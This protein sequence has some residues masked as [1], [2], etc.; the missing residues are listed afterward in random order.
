MHAAQ[1]QRHGDRVKPDDDIGLQRQENTSAGRAGA[2]PLYLRYTALHRARRAARQSG[3]E[4]VC[5]C[6]VGC[7]SSRQPRSPQRSMVDATAGSRS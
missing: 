5:R 3:L 7:I 1:N 2:Q 6:G 4:R